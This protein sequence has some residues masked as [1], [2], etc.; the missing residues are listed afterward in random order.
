M[1]KIVE[2]GTVI[3][4]DGDTVRVIIDQGE[5]CR[6]CGNAALG[7]C[8][9]GGAGMVLDVENILGAGIGDVVKIGIDKDVQNRGY[10]LAYVVPLMFLVLGTVIGHL[11]GGFYHVTFLDAV[12]GFLFLGVSLYFS[13]RAINAMDRSQRMH[14]KEIVEKRQY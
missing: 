4:R 6:K 8:K 7:L 14:V 3:A 2:T 9:P 13:L 11:L 1:K 5:S 12:M 10:A